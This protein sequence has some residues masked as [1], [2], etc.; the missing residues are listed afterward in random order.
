M[1]LH[2]IISLLTFV[3]AAS[4]LPL[5]KGEVVESSHNEN[6]ARIKNSNMFGLREKDVDSIFEKRYG[7]RKLQDNSPSDMPSKSLAPSGTP[8]VTSVNPPPTPSPSATPSATPS[9]SPSASASPTMSPSKS[10]TKA[11]ANPSQP[12]TVKVKCKKDFKDDPAGCNAVKCC[13][14]KNKKKKCA[15]N[16]GVECVIAPPTKA[17]VKIKCKKL[18]DSTSCKASGACKWV[19]KKNK[20]K[21]PNKRMKRKK[22]TGTGNGKKNVLANAGKRKKKNQ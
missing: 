16:K 20:C 6:R 7:Y 21:K 4:S 17:P 15:K 3:L 18:K 14:Y 19:A 5:S 13:K 9:A 12:T 11:P 8:T 1:L 22:G 10:P 2:Q